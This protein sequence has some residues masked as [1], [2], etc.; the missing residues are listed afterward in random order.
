MVICNKSIYIASVGD[1]RAILSTT[2]QLP[3]IVPFIPRVDNEVATQLKYS[4][5][6]QLDYE[7]FFLQL[8]RDQKPEDQEEYERI[9]ESGGRVKRL[10]DEEG[11]RIG[12]YRV[13][14]FERN[15]PGLTMTRSIGD[16][17]AKH[18]GVISTPIITTHPLLQDRDLFIVVA[19]DGI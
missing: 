16:Q 17:T 9:K 8:T 4:R 14:E 3:S 13:W 2:V 11:N 5:S 15:V 19:S 1:S 12:P 10:I 18:I 6:S 7:L